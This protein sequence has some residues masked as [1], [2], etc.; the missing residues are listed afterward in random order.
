M[1]KEQDL[2]EQ[3][4]YYYQA[5]LEKMIGRRMLELDPIYKR[6]QAKAVEYLE[7]INKEL[8][9]ASDA[10]RASRRYRVK[11]QKAYVAKLLPDLQLL[12]AAQQPYY[13][14]ILAGVLEYGYYTSAYTLEKAAKVVP[15][16][17]VLNRSGVL[18]MIANPWLPDRNTYSDRIRKNNQLVADKTAETVKDLVTR[19]LNY[20]EAAK[21]LSNKIGEGYY[22]ATRLIRTEMKRANSLGSSYAAMENANILEGKYWD[23]TLDGDTSARCA[24][25]DV[26]ARNGEIFDLDYDTP[27]NPG[28]PGKRIPN[29]PHC[30]CIYVNKLRYI[31]PISKRKAKGEDGKS[32]VTTASTYDDYA[33]ERGLPTVKEMLEKDNPRRYLRPGETIDSIKQK[34]VRKEFNGH[35]ITASRA[36][37]DKAAD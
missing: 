27:A 25:N 4:A 12:E 14:E 30:R 19:R 17:R 36:P 31:A 13:T 32:Y 35:T 11:M 20:S 29:H 18:G 22:N 7:Q 8:A 33:K 28:V 6:L 37:W 16:V 10:V 1:S 24:E 23:A 3:Y 9:E 34:V 5:Q 21:D 26:A 15:T 2:L